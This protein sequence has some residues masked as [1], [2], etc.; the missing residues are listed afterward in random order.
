MKQSKLTSGDVLFIFKDTFF[1]SLRKFI[2]RRSF[3]NCA[4][5]VEIID[6]QMVVTNRRGVL[7][8][9][10]LSTFMELHKSFV[11]IP[12][13]KGSEVMKPTLKVLGTKTKCATHIS[14]LMALPLSDGNIDD[15]HK[16]LDKI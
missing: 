16:H 4:V 14:K 10:H 11:N 7:T 15:L 6:T 2:T 5:Y 12:A 13:L 3:T 9:M 8:L 1:G